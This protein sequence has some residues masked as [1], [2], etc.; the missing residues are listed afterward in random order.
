MKEFKVFNEKVNFEAIS[1]RS[2]ELDSPLIG[3]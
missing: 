1:V 3:T 2:P